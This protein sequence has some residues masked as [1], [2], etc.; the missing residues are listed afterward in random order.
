MCTEQDEKTALICA[1]VTRL[2]RHVSRK[3]E[4]A[5]DAAV[6]VLVIV[7]YGNVVLFV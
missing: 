2:L 7:I 6:I 5:V 3:L 1:N 4:T